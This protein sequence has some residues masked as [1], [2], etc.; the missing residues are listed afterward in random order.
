MLGT[1]EALGKSVSSLSL[2]FR[3]CK[4]LCSFNFAVWGG[5]RFYVNVAKLPPL[6]FSTMNFD[7][8]EAHGQ[9]WPVHHCC[10]FWSHGRYYESIAE[11]LLTEPVCG[12]RILVNK[13]LQADTTNTLSDQG[14]A[15][16]QP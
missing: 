10:R 15:P 1:C 11:L 8:V 5:F 12:L 6:L 7:S 4:V 3:I 9:G 14:L 13:A 16:P 2:S